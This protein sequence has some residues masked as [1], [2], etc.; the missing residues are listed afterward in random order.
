MGRYDVSVGVEFGREKEGRDWRE[1]ETKLREI[2]RQRKRKK[3]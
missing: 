1:R 3:K 2:E